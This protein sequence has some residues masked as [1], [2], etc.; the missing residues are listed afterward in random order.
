M[1][2]L[3]FVLV[4]YEKPVTRLLLNRNL[5]DISIEILSRPG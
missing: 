4:V 5:H 2:L 3:W 1:L